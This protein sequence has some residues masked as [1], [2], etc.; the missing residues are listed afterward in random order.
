LSLFKHVKL[1]SKF[2]QSISKK[3]ID[4]VNYTFLTNKNC[5]ISFFNSY[6]CPLENSFKLIFVNCLLNYDGK[7]FT[8]SYPWNVKGKTGRL[9][10]PPIKKKIHI[11]FKDDWNMSNKKS[12]DF[13]LNYVRKK[14]YFSNSILKNSLKALY[15]IFLN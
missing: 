4:N 3:N 10:K 12:V 14:K 15:F 11:N 9:I 8:F 2:K 7:K 6:T 5:Y 13:F 1:L